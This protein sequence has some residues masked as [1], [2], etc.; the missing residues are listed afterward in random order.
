VAEAHA[1]GEPTRRARRWPVDGEGLD[2]RWA[3]NVLLNKWLEY[4]VERGHRFGVAA[5]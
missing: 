4:C 1:V 3:R 2:A 5:P